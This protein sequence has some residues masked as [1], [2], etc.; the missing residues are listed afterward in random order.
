[1]NKGVWR[2]TSSRQRA[3]HTQRPWGRTVSGVLEEQRGGCVSGA[4][5]A[6]GREGGKEGWERTGRSCRGLRAAR[7]LRH[8]DILKFQ[9]ISN[10]IQYFVFNEAGRYVTI[11]KDSYR[12]EKNLKS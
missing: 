1:M 8:C 11:L 5:W 7:A 9:R 10:D 6:R 3:Q 4:E 2:N 12:F